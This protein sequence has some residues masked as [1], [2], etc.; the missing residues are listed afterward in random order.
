MSLEKTIKNILDNRG[1]GIR[2]RNYLLEQPTDKNPANTPLRSTHAYGDSGTPIE[3]QG[4]WGT[5][6][7]DMTPAERAQHQIELANARNAANYAGNVVPS[8]RANEP[9]E[10][11]QSGVTITQRTSQAVQM[12]P[13]A[14]SAKLKTMDPEALR[15]AGWENGPPSPEEI[16]AKRQALAAARVKMDQ[17]R[18]EGQPASFTATGQASS[19]G[20]DAAGNRVFDKSIQRAREELV[21]SQTPEIEAQRA[22]RAAQRD[23]LGLQNTEAGTSPTPPQSSTA[24][25][26][27]SQPTQPAPGSGLTPGNQQRVASSRRRGGGGNVSTGVAGSSIN[28]SQVQA[29]G[30]NFGQKSLMA[31]YDPTASRKKFIMEKVMRVIQN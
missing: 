7:E 31:S 6:P 9:G 10:V 29:R 21:K 1:L 23:E 20:F 16:I 5:R 3:P 25:T 30:F 8:S 13:V 19:L 2:P 11:Q 15:L 4:G 18:P 12:D 22:E 27:S 28:Q 24:P 26:P 14:L 17:E